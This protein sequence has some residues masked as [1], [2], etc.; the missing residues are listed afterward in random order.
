MECN[1]WHCELG[2]DCAHRF[3]TVPQSNPVPCHQRLHPIN[4]E[5]NLRVTV[6]PFHLDTRVWCKNST[7]D[8]MLEFD[9]R[10]LHDV[11]FPEPVIRHWNALMEASF[12]PELHDSGVRWIAYDGVSPHADMI[13][14]DIDVQTLCCYLPPDHL[15]VHSKLPNGNTLYYWLED[16]SDKQLFSV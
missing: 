7:V 3:A 11:D 10:A 5:R 15:H 13:Q 1:E 12:P 16:A 9:R 8:D 4:E 2:R 14:T 6:G